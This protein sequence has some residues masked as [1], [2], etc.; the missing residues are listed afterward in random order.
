MKKFLR[1]VTVASVVCLSLSCASTKQQMADTRPRFQEAAT[2]NVVLKFNSWDYIYMIQPIYRDDGFL[3]QIKRD[4]LGA[5]LD[6]FGVRREL[7]VVV[8]G[9]S[10][11]GRREEM[12]DAWKTVLSAHG[13]QRIVCV[14]ASVSGE[15]NGSVILDDSQLRAA[16]PTRTAKL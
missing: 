4:S 16:Q 12:V 9:W 3:H 1:F 14:R 11:D 7:A 2:A 13:F 10:Y 5:A 8:I 15:I 6:Q